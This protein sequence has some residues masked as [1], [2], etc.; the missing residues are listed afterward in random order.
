MVVF[1]TAT[2]VDLPT[3]V[4]VEAATAGGSSALAGDDDDDVDDDDDDGD[5]DGMLALVEG[6]S[7]VSSSDS[8]NAACRS[9]DRA[10]ICT[11]K[12]NSGDPSACDTKTC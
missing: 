5:D 6:V 2:A 12:V 4:E 3:V 7:L 9:I 8:V 1:P 10:C 11:P